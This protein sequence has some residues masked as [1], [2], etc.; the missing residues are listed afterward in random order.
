LNIA[1]EISW[2]Q[3]MTVVVPRFVAG[4]GALMALWL[5]Q[6]KAQTLDAVRS[7]LDV[8]IESDK[9]DRQKATE[10]NESRHQEHSQMIADTNRHASPISPLG[11]PTSRP[12]STMLGITS[13]VTSSKRT[14]LGETCIAVD[15]SIDRMQISLDLAVSTR[16]DVRD[17][18][19][20]LTAKAGKST[21][22]P[23]RRPAA[24]PT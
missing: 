16:G 17:E 5:F 9:K 23:V 2:G 21:V 1:A 8:F 7:M 4:G 12:R 24:K 14:S 3:I 15:K 20:M 19:I 22:P 13:L 11:S 18:A 6:L 10:A